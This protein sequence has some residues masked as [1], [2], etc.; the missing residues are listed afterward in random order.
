MVAG[1]TPKL[2][3]RTL[4]IEPDTAEG[5]ALA[6]QLTY[7]ERDDFD[8]RTVASLGEARTVLAEEQIDCVVTRHDPPV[9]DGVEILSA[10]RDD[11]TDLPILLATGTAYA[12]HVLDS[13]A[14]G[15]VEMTNGEVHEGFVANQIESVVSRVHERRQYEAQLEAS[16]ETLERLHRITSDPDTSFTEQV[17]QMLAFGSDVFGMDIAFLAR[18][19]DEAGDFEVVA[20]AGD[21]ELIQAGVTS[22]LSETYC[23]RTVAD[24]TTSPLAVQNAPDDMADDPAF[25]KFGLGCY[26]GAQINVN[27]ELYGTLCFA[28][29]DPRQPGFSEDEKALIEIIAQW[30]RQQL[31]QREYRRELETA[32]DRFEQTLERVDD[33]FFAVDTDWRVTYVNEVGKEV[34]RKAMGLGDGADIVGRHL[35]E[36]IPEAVETTFYQQYHHALEAQESVSFESYF[37]PMDV[38]FEVRAYPDEEGLS[39]YFTD[40]TERK[41]Q[42]RELER[43]QN[44]L[45]Q[46]ERVADIGGWEINIETMD[47]FWTEHLFDLLGVEYDEEPSYDEALDVYHEADRPVVEQAV[48]EAIDAE[49]PFDVELRYW[50]SDDDLRWL[51]VQGVPIT[52]D[53]GE[54]VMVR[55][56]AQDVTERKDREQTLNALLSASRTF[57]EAANEDALVTALIDEVERIFDYDIA[58][59]RLH[60]GDAGTLPPTKFSP[61]AREHVPEPPTYNDD[62]GVIGHTFQSKEPLVIDS[63]SEATA[64]DYGQ[65][66]SG[67]F[68]P[69]GDH[70]VLSVG[71]V[72]PDAFDEEDVALVEL[73]A[74]TAASAFDR[75]ERETEMRQLQRILNHL[76]EKVFLLAEDGEL[77]FVTEPLATYLGRESDHLVGT[78]LT[79]LVPPTEQ[80]TI[81]DALQTIRTASSENAP[82]NADALCGL[83]R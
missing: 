4:L 35:W 65:V 34:L 66:E 15:I 74:L 47:V 21:H 36:N 44:L 27:G 60:D 80:S 46:T 6:S 10:L 81:E 8:L 82:L 24:H 39:V 26:L 48:E 19:D 43:F 18:I 73:L 29:N 25:K 40:V 62:E 20:A 31:E 5:E 33:S 32:R 22:E 64:V 71:S 59:V 17:Q 2:A 79:S 55:G 68:F 63:L 76:E 37:D 58:S 78:T 23:R 50:K 83:Y 54:V 51:R 14:T 11:Y 38:W 52:N 67:L 57:I 3:I 42:E 7:A 13:S 12:D 49:E 1:E 56:S 41:G 28:D 53:D 45:N 16:Q 72:E 61:Q 69:L 30:L 9:I 77:T 75:L 70:G